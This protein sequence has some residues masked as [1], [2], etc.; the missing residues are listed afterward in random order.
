MKEQQNENKIKFPYPLKEEK[1]VEKEERYFKKL[2]KNII[3]FK[4]FPFLEKKDAK[5]FGK[6]NSRFH[7]SFANFYEMLMGNLISKYNL[8]LEKEY[9]P[10]SIN[11]QKDDKGHFV[12]LNYYKEEHYLLF[13]YNE[14]THRNDSKYWEKI[15]PQNSLLNK[16]IYRLKTV[17][18]IDVNSKMSHI[19]NGKYKLYINHC[20]CNL[21]ENKLKMT[22]LLD[23]L[24]LQEFVYP[25]RTQ[26]NTCRSVH[27][28]GSKEEVVRRR[29]LLRPA[30]NAVKTIYNKDNKLNK[31]FIMEISINYNENLDKSNGHEISIKFDHSDGSWKENWLID[32]VILE[33]EKEN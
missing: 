30:R 33:K 18:W 1:V 22:V 10:D 23:G 14:W 6:I 21:A 27:G 20:V 26:V 32:G 13:L 29:P 4:I 15:T 31:D 2:T 3:S 16:D 25:S 5:E 12:K 19:Y 8:K 11:E 28:D 9:K 24:P 17:C 7:N